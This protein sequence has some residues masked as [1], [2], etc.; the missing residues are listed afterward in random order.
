MRGR[1]VAILAVLA[2][3]VLAMAAGAKEIDRDFHR[4]FDVSRGV[5]LDLRHGDGD[6]TIKPWDKDAIDVTVRYR[7]DVSRIGFGGDPDFDVEFKQGDDY[8]SVIGRETPAGPSV[9]LVVKRY[10]YVY[11]ISAPAYVRLDLEGDDGD[12]EIAE[13][14]A[15]IDCMIDDGDVL[16]HDI[17]N[18]RTRVAFE[19]GDLSISSLSGELR[20]SGDDGDVDLSD[21]DM[22]TAKISV[23]DGDVTAARCSGDLSIDAEDGDIA[24]DLTKSASVRV[25]TEDGDVEIGLGDQG[26]GDVDV[27]TDDGGV[28]VTLSPGSAFSFLVTMDDG[29]VRVSLPERDRF[30]E[31]DHSVS[32]VVRGGGGHVRVRTEDGTVL[33][34]EA[35]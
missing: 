12:V 10:E 34:R 25:R 7:A 26:V 8:V 4:S 3:A 16:L 13:W 9:M 31:D 22:P 19:D 23:C 14:R 17:V 29:H 15:E 6:V 11:T 28:T 20:L 32:G 5:R 24:L 27:G 30:E 2:V 33:I 35:S 21:C 18:E 1:G